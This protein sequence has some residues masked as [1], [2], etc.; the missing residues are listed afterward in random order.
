MEHETNWAKLGV[1]F[2]AGTVGLP[3][4]SLDFLGYVPR[5][6]NLVSRNKANNLTIYYNAQPSNQNIH[7]MQH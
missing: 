6:L 1:G 3:N 5:C 7:Y 2:L 4:N